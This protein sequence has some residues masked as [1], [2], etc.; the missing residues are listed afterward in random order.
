MVRPGET[1]WLA[2]V[3]N[4]WALREAID[5]ALGNEKE[6]EQMG[7]RAL[8]VVENEY[9]LERQAQQYK[10]LYGDILQTNSDT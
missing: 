3:G 2:E 6:R 5:Q 1:G 8:E 10:E 4:V 7:M 9:T